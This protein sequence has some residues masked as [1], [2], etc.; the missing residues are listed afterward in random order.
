ME[1]TQ[2]VTLKAEHET[3]QEQL[4][5]KEADLTKANLE[6]SYFL[7]YRKCLVEHLPVKIMFPLNFQK[8]ILWTIQIIIWRAKENTGGI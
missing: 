8:A 7:S 1:E 6:V 3:V 2:L 5:L 4:E